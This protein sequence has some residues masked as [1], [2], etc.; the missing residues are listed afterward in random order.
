M[1]FAAALEWNV[2]TGEGA[3]LHDPCTLAWL[4]APE[5]FELRPCHIDVETAS[6]LSLGHT[7]VEFRAAPARAMTARWAT[8]AD[9]A[10]VFELLTRRL[11]SL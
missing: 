6:P 3:P 10:G 1:D 9:G 8:H 4:L 5:L 7:A 2:A 11:A